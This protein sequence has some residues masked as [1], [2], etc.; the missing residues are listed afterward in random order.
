[1]TR[2]FTGGMQPLSAL[3]FPGIWTDAAAGDGLLRGSDRRT[4]DWIACIHEWDNA[5][6]RRPSPMNLPPQEI[7]KAYDIRGVVGKSLTTEGVRLIGQALGSELLERSSGG[8]RPEIA[9]GRDGRLS[10]PELA[11]ALS[12]GIRASGVDVAEIGCSRPRSLISPHTNWAAQ[13]GRGH[14]QPQPARVQRIEDGARGNDLG[15]RG[16]PAT[17]P[18][19]RVGPARP[20]RRAAPPRR[21]SA[22]PT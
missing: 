21:E 18:A 6:P 7:F 19:D 22:R 15:R 10:G 2:R 8:E 9:L 4:R 3:R 1:M 12:E 11:Q 17:A 5:G 13:R 14:G 16:R 20:R